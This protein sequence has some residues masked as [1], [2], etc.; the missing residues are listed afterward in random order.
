LVLFEQ[1]VDK[2]YKQNQLENKLA[3]TKFAKAQVEM[4]HE[5]E[6]LL[7]VKIMQ[8]LKYDIYNIGF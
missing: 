3:E 7:R 1:Q 5:K 4:M 6:L 2:L 8:I